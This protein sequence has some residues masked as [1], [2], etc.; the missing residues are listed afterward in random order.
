MR[1][2]T[3]VLI[4]GVGPLYFEAKDDLAHKFQ[5]KSQSG[6]ILITVARRANNRMHIQNCAQ[7][8]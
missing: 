1:I 5:L 6:E 4:G 7:V 3:Q 8:S 2:L